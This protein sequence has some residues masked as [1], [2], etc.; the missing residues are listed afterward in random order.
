MARVVI[1]TRT[2]P[3]CKFVY[4]A[5]EFYKTNVEYYGGV[6]KIPDLVRLFNEDDEEVLV[7][8]EIIKGT[9]F[10]LI[11]NPNNNAIREGDYNTRV[12]YLGMFCSNCGAFLDIDTCTLS[13]EVNE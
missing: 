4:E 7:D 3:V 9:E 11:E 2:C 5:K 1:K 12:Q 6:E 8:T 13:K 10:K